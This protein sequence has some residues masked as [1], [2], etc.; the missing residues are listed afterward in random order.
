MTSFYAPPPGSATDPQAEACQLLQDMFQAASVDESFQ[1]ICCGDGNEVP[2]ASAIEST[3]N[4]YG[5]R[6]L[7]QNV[8]T[9][10]QGPHEIDWVATSRPNL[11]EMPKCSNL[12]LSDHNAVET[13][14]SVH[15]KD[16]TRG[17]LQATVSWEKPQE[18]AQEDWRNLLEAAWASNPANATFL[19]AVCNRSVE[20]QQAWD[21]YMCLLRDMFSRAFQNDENLGFCH[22]WWW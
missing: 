15:T 11:M 18:V 16:C 1:W 21:D 10:W 12:V 20:V 6:V 17:A 13:L 5:G 7:V 22:R 2:G 3:R 9:R 14:V 8:P 4:A 19:E